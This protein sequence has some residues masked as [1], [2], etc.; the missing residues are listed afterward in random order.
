M[1]SIRYQTLRTI[2]YVQGKAPGIEMLRGM[3]THALLFRLDAPVTIT[4]GAGG[5]LQF[6]HGLVRMSGYLAATS[7]GYQ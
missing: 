6:G 3:K 1:R 4:G 2:S 5:I 7:P